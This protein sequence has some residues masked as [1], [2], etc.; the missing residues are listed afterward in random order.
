MVAPWSMF[1]RSV[2]QFETHTDERSWRKAAPDVRRGDL[3]HEAKD[4]SSRYRED[5]GSPDQACL[6]R[7]GEDNAAAWN[8]QRHCPGKGVTQ[9]GG[10]RC[11]IR[12]PVAA[13]FSARSTFASFRK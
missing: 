2:P 6:F 8:S 5:L 10:A 1:D 9:S 12:Q 7:Q 3:G 11:G 13:R 4:Q